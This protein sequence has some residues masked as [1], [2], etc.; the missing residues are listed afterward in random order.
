MR[1]S[2]IDPHII[3]AKVKD[4][5]Q[6]LEYFGVKV[7][8]ARKHPQISPVTIFKSLLLIPILRLKSLNQLDN[9]LRLPE[10]I[11][12]IGSKRKMVV[13]D[14]T[15]ERSLA[16]FAIDSVRKILNA[17]V[18]FARARGYHKITLASGRRMIAGIVDGTEIGKKLCSVFYEIG[19]VNLLVDVE[20]IKK[21][22]KELEASW[23]LMEK[24]LCD[25]E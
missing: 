16:G 23:K 3:I 9:Y 7:K 4:L 24:H 20:R 12:F 6:R 15:M 14:S 22:G 10:G 19:K 1:T 25:K 5:C 2:I 21:R 13:S 11:R 17:V 18:G 8:D